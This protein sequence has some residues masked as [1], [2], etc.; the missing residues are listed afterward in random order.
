MDDSFRSNK[1]TLSVPQL[2]AQITEL[3]KAI[4]G[5]YRRIE[6]RTYAAIREELSPFDP[7]IGAS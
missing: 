5:A 4:A 6:Q 7:E 3:G 1:S 2:R